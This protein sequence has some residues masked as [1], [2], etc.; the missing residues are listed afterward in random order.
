MKAGR[1]FDDKVIILFLNKTDLLEKKIKE[2]KELE[3]M[4][5]DL[6]SKCM[7]SVFEH[8]DRKRDYRFAQNHT[9]KHEMV[10]VRPRPTMI[11]VMKSLH[12]ELSEDQI[13]HWL[14]S[15][16][17][18]A[19][20]A[21]AENGDDGDE[22]AAADEHAAAAEDPDADADANAPEPSNVA[23]NAEDEDAETFEDAVSLFERDMSQ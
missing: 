13:I 7:Q 4:G 15:Q 8:P 17:T 14:E 5:F 19:R 16:A 21:D 3:F 18:A 12:P 20:E 11:H 1:E 6:C 2:G 10:L 9:D 23:P 22:N